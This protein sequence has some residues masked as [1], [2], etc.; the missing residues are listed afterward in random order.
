MIK[1]QGSPPK[2]IDVRKIKRL[3]KL[4]TK[5]KP[6]KGYKTNPKI[7]TPMKQRLM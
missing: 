3:T 2:H 7:T 1:I 5:I 6:K 4:L